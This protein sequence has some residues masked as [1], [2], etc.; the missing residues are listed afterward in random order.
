MPVHCLPDPLATVLLLDV[1]PRTR[2]Q[3]EAQGLHLAKNWPGA[4]LCPLDMAK[5]KQGGHRVVTA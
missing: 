3:Y 1:V 4:P 2:S 5:K